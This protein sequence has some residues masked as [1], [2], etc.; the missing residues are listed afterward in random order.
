[1]PKSIINNFN[2]DSSFWELNPQTIII[3]NE[4]YEKDNSKNKTDSSKIMWAI[5][6][7][8]DPNDNN[9]FRFVEY[10]QKMKDIE[11]G[12]IKDKKF[13]WVYYDD[14]IETYKKYVLTKSEYTLHVMERKLEERVKLLND[15]PVT[16]EN[17]ELID[18]VQLNLVKIEKELKELRKIVK[19]E[20]SNVK[21]KG[22]KKLGLLD[23]GM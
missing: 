5:S 9:S 18:K 8:V 10:K 16:L 15:T 2:I 1:M 6:L 17:V 23:S 12:Y 22:D 20:D 3:F 4:F 21:A 14:I 19:E 13:E 7:L 11:S